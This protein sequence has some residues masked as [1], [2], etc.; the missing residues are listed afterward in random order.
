VNGNA[1]STII[2]PYSAFAITRQL[3]N[4]NLTLVFSGRVTPVAV[5]TKLQ[6]QGSV[7]TSTHFATDVK[8]SQLQFGSNWSMGTSVL[9]ADTLSVWDA[10]LN[11]FDVYYQMP[12][13]TW[14][15]FPDATT[16]QSSV[17]IAAGT[18]TSITKR[19]AVAG[20]ATFL[21][22]PLPYSLD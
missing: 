19:T 1:N 8:L 12:D 20:S 16:D 2:Y 9:T 14:R 6:S 22:T 17:T 5:S 13:T 10:T 3:A 11:R 21:Q 7:L 15:K 18:V 4:G